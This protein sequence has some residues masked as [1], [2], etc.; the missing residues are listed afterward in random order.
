[1]HGSEGSEL[2]VTRSEE[3]IWPP[4]KRKASQ[5]AKKATENFDF[6]LRSNGFLVPIFRRRAIFRSSGPSFSLSPKLIFVSSSSS[7]FLLL[8]R[9]SEIEPPLLP[10]HL[11]NLIPFPLPLLSSFSKLAEKLSRI[12]GRRRREI[13]SP[14]RLKNRLNSCPN[15]FSFFS[16]VK[17]YEHMTVFD[18][19]GQASMNTVQCLQSSSPLR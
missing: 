3:K 4:E 17:Y 1:M 10:F 18:R 5:K 19:F 15:H 8:L 16:I 7:T 11:P 14:V 9:P 6:F 12:C 13:G 2:A